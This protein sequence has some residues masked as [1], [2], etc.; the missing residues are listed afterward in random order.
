[1]L[2]EKNF[3]VRIKFVYTTDYYVVLFSVLE[4]DFYLS[5]CY[6]K[7]LTLNI[8]KFSSKHRYE[9][10]LLTHY[11]THYTT[12]HSDYKKRVTIFVHTFFL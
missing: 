8:I 12:K 6:L 4:T 3:I 5:F 11:T 7:T 2:Y 1:M 10:I 9:N